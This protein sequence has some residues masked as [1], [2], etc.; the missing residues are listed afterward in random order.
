M[1]IPAPARPESVTAWPTAG[2]VV[3]AV[4]VRLVTSISPRMKRWIVQW[5]VNVPAV[6]N[7]RV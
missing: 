2:W 4:R 5:Y 3:E 6:A 1:P 7:V